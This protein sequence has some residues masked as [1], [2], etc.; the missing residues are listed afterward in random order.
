M[1]DIDTDTDRDSHTHT[2]KSQTFIIIILNVVH[3]KKQSAVLAEDKPT[4][5]S[6]S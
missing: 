4:R 5:V 1:P 2:H 6:N 3:V